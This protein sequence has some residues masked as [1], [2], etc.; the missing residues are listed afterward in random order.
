[1]NGLLRE[2]LR[3]IGGDLFYWVCIDKKNV[4]KFEHLG[5]HRVAEAIF[6]LSLYIVDCHCLG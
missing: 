2:P 6:D 5:L 1:M 4:S 3:F